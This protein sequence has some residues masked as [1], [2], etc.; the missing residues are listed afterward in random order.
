MFSL[1]YLHAKPVF[2]A[3]GLA[4]RGL[5]ISESMPPSY[6]D[7][8]AGSGDYLFMLF[9]DD[10]EIGPPDAQRTLPGPTLVLWPPGEPQHY[11]NLG[12]R[13]R[14]SWIHCNGRT[15][16]KIVRG[17]R[18][19]KLGRVRSF[20]EVDLTR[21]DRDLLSIHEEMTGNRPADGVVVRNL[22]ENLIRNG[23]RP[24]PSPGR[25]TRPEWVERVRQ[26]IDAR[27]ETAVRLADLAV[28]ADLSERHLCTQFRRHFGCPPMAYLIRRRLNAAAVLLRG[29]SVPVGEVGRRVGFADPFYF[30]KQFK[31]CFGAPPSSL[32]SA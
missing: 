6:I 31:A 13:W 10:I 18:A 24:R 30:S 32:R 5:G 21:F 25:P 17:T 14:H 27:Y 23:V 11:G 9:H 3:P 19:K 16:A 22:L 4:I 20:T 29:T 15:V 2:R 1:R 26:H 7:R 12:R 28:V 8:A